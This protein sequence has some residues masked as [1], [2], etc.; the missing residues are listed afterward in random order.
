[1]NQLNSPLEEDQWIPLQ[2]V[3]YQ[4]VSNRYIKIMSWQNG[5]F[6]ALPLFGVIGFMLFN[7]SAE[8]T[9]LLYIGLPLW[10]LIPIVVMYG[11]AYC[12]SLGF[13]LRP[14]D[15]V[16]KEGVW[17]RSHTCLPLSRLQ[18]VTLSQGPIAKYFDYCTLK[19][20]SAGSPMAEITIYGLTKAEGER[21]RQHLMQQI[22]DQNG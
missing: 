4:G 13:A 21:L 2:Q 1:M 5:L 14:Q 22:G 18:H 12:R 3:Q 11:R 17:W 10:L 7:R 20:F 19:G 9:T 8:A 15:I 6:S 16:V